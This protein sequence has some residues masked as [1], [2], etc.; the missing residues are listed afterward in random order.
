MLAFAFIDETGSTIKPEIIVG[1]GDQ[2]ASD[3]DGPRHS[4]RTETIA[5]FNSSIKQANDDARA[6]QRLANSTLSEVAIHYKDLL[7]LRRLE[8]ARVSGE[9]A[10]A[11]EE[12]GKLRE[13]NTALLVSMAELCNRSDF[14]ETIRQLFGQRPEL[15]VG[16]LKDLVGG[17]GRLLGSDRPGRLLGKSPTGDQSNA[18][19]SADK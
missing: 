11:N 8:Y 17:L 19:D 13:E 4:S 9:L 6:A 2:S 16:S 7:E 10:K 1:T 5:V 3:S 14:A 12:L 15:L 18:I